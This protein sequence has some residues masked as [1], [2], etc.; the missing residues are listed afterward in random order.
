MVLF[1]IWLYIIALGG[2]AV[3]F[4]GKPTNFLLGHML[5]FAAGVM[6]YISYGD[7]LRHAEEDLGK[8]GFYLSNVW[9][10][11]GMGFF[12]LVIHCIPSPSVESIFEPDTTTTT[13]TSTNTSSE[14]VE[15]TPSKPS[16]PQAKSPK[17]ELGRS[18]LRNRKVSKS[19]SRKQEK[20]QNQ[21]KEKEN[22]SITTDQN[23]NKNIQET[24][25]MRQKLFTTGLIA[26]LG[27]TLHNFP[28]GLIVYNASVVCIF[29]YLLLLFNSSM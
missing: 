9:F 8:D 12:W 4:I 6:M 21:E 17:S 22:N 7:L 23:I 11:I 14:T 10:F 27:I 19:P 16:T 26:V 1:K 3:V 25:N 18:N 5:S 20:Q 24:K 13:V 28:E 29:I 2:V 15:K